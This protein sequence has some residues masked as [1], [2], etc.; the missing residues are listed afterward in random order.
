MD[1]GKCQTCGAL[2][3]WA[4]SAKTGKRMPLDPTPRA[5]G[6]V[7]VRRGKISDTYYFRVLT[8]EQ[9]GDRPLYVA[10]FTTCPNAAAHRR[11]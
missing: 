5:D 2:I 6:N 10:H 9:Q 8:P 4:T 1:E 3:L 7:E 11:R